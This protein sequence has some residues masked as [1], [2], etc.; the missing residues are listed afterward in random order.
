[1]PRAF[2]SHSGKDKFYVNICAEKLGFHNCIY[3][4]LTFEEGN[5]MFDEIVK[6]LNQTDVFVIFISNNALQSKWVQ[7][8]LDIAVQLID[9]GLIQRVL[10]IIID[11]NIT[12][13]DV[14]IPEW[15]RKN[16]ILQYVARPKVAARKIQQRLREV[17]WLYHPRLKEKRKIFVGRN[18][19]IQQ[20]EER[21]DEFDA[22]TSVCLIAAGVHGVGRRALLRNCLTKSNIINES[23]QQPTIMLNS[24]ESLEDFIHKVFDLG[25]SVSA[26]LTNFMSL[27]IHEKLDIAEKLV[28]DAQ[29]AKEIIFILDKGCIVSPERDLS[30]WFTLL[31]KR[32]ETNDRISFGI[33]SEFRL[34]KNNIRGI[35]NLYYLEIP[36]L[37]KKERQGLLKRYL[38]FENLSLTLNDFNLFSDLLNG[39]PDQVFY[40]VELIKNEGLPIAKKKCYQIV[41][42]NSERVVRLLNKYQNNEQAIILLNI[43]SR[44]EF[45]SYDLIFEIIGQEEHYQDLINQ[46]FAEAIC[47]SLGANREYIRLND[48]VKDYA[49]RLKLSLPEIYKKK[50]K[51]H[52]DRFLIDYQSE[53]CDVSDYLISMKQALSLGY[54]VNEKYLIPS[55]FLKTM[56]E[57]YNES[58]Y[59][60]VINLADRVLQS[61][62][63][64]DVNIT[65]EIR[66][67]LCLSL[68]RTR[69]KRFLGEVQAINGPDH[70]FLFGF[71]YRLMGNYTESIK[72]LEEVLKERPNFSRAKRELVQVYNLVEDYNK[73]FILAKENY[74]K[75]PN[76]PYHIH[77]Y[78]TCLLKA[79]KRMQNESEI[80]KC[81]ENLDGINSDIA[82]EMSLRGQAQYWAYYKNN[83][84]KALEKVEQAINKFTDSIYPKFTKFDICV[85]F[86]NL[87][88]M[89]KVIKDLEKQISR[90]SYLTNVFLSMKVRY[91]IKSN[92]CDE[93][94][95]IVK[96]MK[97]Y[98][99]T[100]INR[101][102]QLIDRFTGNNAV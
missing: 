78:L 14:R 92:K 33:A 47:E 90:K 87:Q 15:L 73:A 11:K 3:D 98:P 84:T 88:E 23:Y 45:I 36:E 13:N 6:H 95:M 28:L 72:R 25:F 81:L 35:G 52:V 16:Y 58:R 71:Y 42:F 91:L 5:Q 31:L 46:F 9:D 37:D 10:P 60:D 1:M 77:A 50:L 4:S 17:S 57:L 44:F 101:L 68:A 61:Q 67:F 76:N 56:T 74:T 64:M 99:E 53:E 94:K 24:H 48:A 22:Q 86:D 32:L 85:K 59:E 80:D 100:S 97:N 96:S 49:S 65:K 30:N 41:E 83:E 66:Y 55:H 2:L 20:F 102:K 79:D 21:I 39:F 70:N 26:D 12:H 82:K 93:A 29:N 54:D 43:L 8:E 38:E 19:L 89:E 69:N 27:S 62:E 34:F 40:T 51:E 7:T 63:Y 18:E 75:E